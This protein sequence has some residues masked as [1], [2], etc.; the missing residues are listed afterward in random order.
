[1]SSL[2]Q[3]LLIITWNTENRAA[4]V[5][6]ELQSLNVNHAIHLKYGQ[7]IVKNTHGQVTAQTKVAPVTQGEGTIAGAITG[8][9]VSLLIQH[10]MHQGHKDPGILHDVE[11]LGTTIGA[12]AGAGA[13]LAAVSTFANIVPKDVVQ[14]VEKNLTSRSSALI[15]VIHIDDV[16]KVVDMLKDYPDG[17][18]VQTSLPDNIVTQLA[19]VEHQG[20]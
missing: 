13:G 14:S 9:V 10:F 1:M 20:S 17:T 19:S 18:I 2:P 12:A 3:E 6:D 8:G 4:K 7:I 15:A 16:A 11:D 5:L